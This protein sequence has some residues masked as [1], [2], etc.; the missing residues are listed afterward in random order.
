MSHNNA[1]ESQGWYMAP[2]S[3]SNLKLL[4]HIGQYFPGLAPHNLFLMLSHDT[5]DL[6]LA[7]LRLA[8]FGQLIWG[9][10]VYYI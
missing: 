5:I 7:L 10:S 4:A 3:P 2:R 8:I 1:K 6:V 9:K